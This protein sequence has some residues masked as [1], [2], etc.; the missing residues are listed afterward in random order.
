MFKSA[1]TTQATTSQAEPEASTSESETE[2][3]TES[4]NPIGTAKEIVEDQDATKFVTK[5]AQSEEEVERLRNARSKTAEARAKQEADFLARL[6]TQRQ[7]VA[8]YNLCT[9]QFYFLLKYNRNTHLSP[10]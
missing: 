1:I 9:S 5:A 3:E 10:Y 6:E 4:S 7:E 8:S 2:S